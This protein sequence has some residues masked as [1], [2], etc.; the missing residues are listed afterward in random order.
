[1]AIENKIKKDYI[2]H[3]EA[4]AL[5]ILCEIYYSNKGKSNLFK[6]AKTLFKKFDLPTSLNLD[7]LNLNKIKLLN[8]IYKNIFLDKKISNFQGIFHSKN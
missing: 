7:Q 1:M 6:F 4:V 8:D 5:G 2:R 3:G